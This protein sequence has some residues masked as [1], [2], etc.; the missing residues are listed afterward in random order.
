MIANNNMKK[1]C[2]SVVM[3]TYQHES[4]I[5]QAIEGVLMQEAN[6]DIELIIADDNSSDFTE[7]IVH[8]LQSS[9][10][11]GAWIHYNK[12]D[13]NKG[14]MPNFVWA[15]S[16]AKGDFI[17]LCEGDDYWTDPHKIQKQ[18]DYLKNNP[19]CAL[20]FHNAYRLFTDGRLELFNEYHRTRYTA[21]DLWHQWLIP[22]AS[23]LY[24][25]DLL[26]YP[27]W[28]I[29]STHGDLGLFLLLGEH[30]LFGC[31]NETMCVYRIHDTGVTQNHFKTIEHRLKHVEQLQEMDAYFESKYHQP[32]MQRIINYNLSAA[33]LLAKCQKKMKAIHLLIKSMKLNFAAVIRNVYFYKTIFCLLFAWKTPSH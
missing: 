2:V 31:I 11:N 16:Q 5:Q 7:K 28:F 12:H 24:R 26:K 14:M 21:Q 10:K 3:I 33:Y 29:K 9:H 18:V 15:L 1:T 19:D 30:G 6:V 32:I 13:T 25:N 20:V 17:S 8:H 27:E 4:Y 22:T 23:A